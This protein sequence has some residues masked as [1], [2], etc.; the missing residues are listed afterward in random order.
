[1]FNIQYLY[2]ERELGPISSFLLACFITFINL[3]LPTILKMTSYQELHLRE[4]QLQVSILIKLLLARYMSKKHFHNNYYLQ[5]QTL[6][7]F[8]SCY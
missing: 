3:L 2:L 6:T 1:M 8:F 7:I 5:Y 4:S